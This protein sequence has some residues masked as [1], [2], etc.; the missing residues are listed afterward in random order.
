MKS[1][2]TVRGPFSHLQAGF[3]PLFE[4]HRT[5]VWRFLC[6]L[7][8]DPRVAEELA[9]QVFRQAYRDVPRDA[10]RASRQIWLFRSALHLAL[11]YDNRSGPP[12]I[13]ERDSLVRLVRHTMAQLE[14][15][16]RAAILMHKYES[17]DYSQIGE[18]LGCS[19]PAVQ[20]LLA[21]A[22]QKLRALA[23]A[24]E[25]SGARPCAGMSA[26]TAA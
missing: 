9:L 11:H 26:D 2:R 6:R 1:L 21:E 17:F 18:V 14:P 25:M 4:R 13:P 20:V 12:A 5:A 15:A 10:L 22:Y 16:Q 19:T 3:G 7:V 24:V 8:D 23:T